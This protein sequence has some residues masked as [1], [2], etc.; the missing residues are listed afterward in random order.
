MKQNKEEYLSNYWLNHFDQLESIFRTGEAYID[1]VQRS[2]TKTF[3]IVVSEFP[4]SKKTPDTWKDWKD[5]SV[6][7]FK[8]AFSDQEAVDPYRVWEFNAFASILTAAGVEVM[9]G[10][11]IRHLNPIYGTKRD[12]KS[13][14][15]WAAQNAKEVEKN[16]DATCIE[17]RPYYEDLRKRADAVQ[18][19]YG[20]EVKTDTV[21]TPGN[22]PRIRNIPGDKGPSLVED[23]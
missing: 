2:A 1:L 8:V 13:M 5:N 20:E 3:E 7:V 11:C 15:L 23:G 21:N 12:S 18:L 6:L 10:T 14:I 17:Y 9:T 22:Y 4:F 16:G 19:G